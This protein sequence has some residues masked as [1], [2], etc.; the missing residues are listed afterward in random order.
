[1][2]D[3]AEARGEGTALQ[4]SL[5][6]MLSTLAVAAALLIAPVLPRI[7]AAFPH[8]PNAEAKVLLALSIPALVVAISAP[9]VGRV[10]DTFGRKRVLLISLGLYLV[11]GVAPFFLD[12]LEHIIL[13]RLGVGL[14]EAGIMTSS[15]ALI[16]DYFKGPRREHWIVVQ[17]AIASI[18]SVMFA[19]IS[20]ALGEF[21]WRAPF[22][23]Y[24]MPVIYIPLVLALIREPAQIET[25]HS[26]ATRFPWSKVAALYAIGFPAAALFFVVP[27]QT[28]FLLTEREMASPQLIGLT[29]ALGGVAVTIG[30]FLFKVISKTALHKILGLAFGLIALGLTLFVGNGEYLVTCIGIAVAS[31]GCGMTL[32]AILTSIMGRLAFEER[33][34]GA[35]GWQTAFF[36]GN[37]LSPLLILTASALFNGLTGAL[38]VAAGVAAFAAL[39]CLG[40]FR[41]AP[42]PIAASVSS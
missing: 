13:S 6:A 2:G 1:M 20:G 38:Y 10:A 33:G 11:S 25:Q 26:A 36:M 29:S 42:S 31:I 23:V 40:V 16:G 7:V 5:L 3:V 30:G 24:A 8:D 21:G 18:A 39:L 9:F 22:L 37:F 34:R 19:V 14:A 27:I 12:S 4:G 15:T 41:F 35:G 32:P 28:P 17:T